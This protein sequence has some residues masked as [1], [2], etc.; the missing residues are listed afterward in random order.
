MRQLH[1]ISCRELIGIVFDCLIDDTRL[2]AV[3]RDDIAVQQNLLAANLQH[4]FYANT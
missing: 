3:Q 1:D 4:V 2:H